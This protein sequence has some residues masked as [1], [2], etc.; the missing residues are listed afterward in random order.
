M[1]V[2]AYNN[3]QKYIAKMLQKILFEIGYTW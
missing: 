3:A 2:N 1:S